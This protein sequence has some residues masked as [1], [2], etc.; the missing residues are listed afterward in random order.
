MQKI[1]PKQGLFSALEELGNQ[2]GRPKKE[3]T[4]FLIFKKKTRKS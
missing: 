2:I 1:K 3:A 4:K